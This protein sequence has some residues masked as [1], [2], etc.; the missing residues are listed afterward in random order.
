MAARSAATR[1]LPGPLISVRSQSRASGV[2]SRQ[3]FTTWARAALG[4]TA[5]GREISVLVVGEQR[6]RAL[7]RRYRGRDKPTN[8]L[9]FPAATAG[10]AQLLGD[11]VICPQVLRREARE[12]H[13][14][15]KDHWTHLFVHGLL[16]LIGYDH[17]R[18][19]DQRRMERREIRI[20]RS[21]GIANPYRSR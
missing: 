1:L 5:P 12:Q 17:E 16:H 7:N 6:S 8:V 4:R 11:L 9:S 2:P 15:L 19:P 14:R 18:A 3:T 10:A 21:M 20:L 13:K